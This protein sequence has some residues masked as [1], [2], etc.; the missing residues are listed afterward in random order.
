M[1]PLFRLGRVVASPAALAAMERAGDTPASLLR[2]HVALDQGALDEGDH[3]AN[4]D[5]LGEPPTRVFSAY[6]LRDGARLWITTEWDRSVTT[7]L[8]PEDY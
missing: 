2:R 3:A 1:T 7:L 5:A 4:L 8:L 6:A